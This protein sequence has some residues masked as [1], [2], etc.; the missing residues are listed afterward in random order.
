M[1]IR[2]FARNHNSLGRDFDSF[3]SQ[4]SLA[5]FPSKTHCCHPIPPGLQEYIN[6][7]TILIDDSPQIMLLAVDFD[8]YFVDVEGVAITSVISFQAAGID[9]TELDTPKADRL[10]GYGNASLS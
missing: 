5:T 3:F 8:E 9:S 7:F 1:V 10:S 2:A 6:H 4:M